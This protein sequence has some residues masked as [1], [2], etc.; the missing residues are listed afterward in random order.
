MVFAQVRGSSKTRRKAL[1]SGALSFQDVP[2][3][4]TASHRS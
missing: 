3:L 2:Q 1:H 4:S